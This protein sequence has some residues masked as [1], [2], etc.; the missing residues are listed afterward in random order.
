MGEIAIQVK[1]N[2]PTMAELNVRYYIPNAG[3]TPFY[4]VHVKDI[5]EKVRL[6]LKAR[7]YQSTT[8]N[9]DNVRLTLSTIN[10]KKNN[11]MP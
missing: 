8:E 4:D 9:W 10:P 2:S 6:T 5:Q 3:W 11:L 7:V 1:V